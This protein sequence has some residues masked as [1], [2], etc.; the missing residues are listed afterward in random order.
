M[1]KTCVKCGETKSL[2]YF[3]KYKTKKGSIC[4]RNDCA[5][6]EKL[7]SKNYYHTNIDS[8][9]EAVKRY[10]EKNR[11]IVRAKKKIYDEQ[12]QEKNRE[13][14]NYYVNTI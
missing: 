3:R 2:T 9:K 5:E 8:C 10:I 4:H 14:R 11:D 13:K 12:Y 1:I 6:C 7:R